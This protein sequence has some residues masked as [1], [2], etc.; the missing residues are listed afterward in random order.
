MAGSGTQGLYN[1][2]VVRVFVHVPIISFRQ[3][4]LVFSNSPNVIPE[5]EDID[6]RCLMLTW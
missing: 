1:G 2:L 6:N 5:N 4:R 3:P